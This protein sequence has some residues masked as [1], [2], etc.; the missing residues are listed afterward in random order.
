[1]I[2]P[3]TVG[4]VPGRFILADSQPFWTRKSATTYAAAP[5]FL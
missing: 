2:G 1:M 4:A 5:F 3:D